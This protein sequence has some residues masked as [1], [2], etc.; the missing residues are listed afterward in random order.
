MYNHSSLTVNAL[1][2]AGGGS[3]YVAADMGASSYIVWA[4]LALT[5]LCLF[6][7]LYRNAKLRVSEKA[8]SKK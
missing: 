4:L 2:V 7:I 8:L 5:V 1:P 3:T 6:A